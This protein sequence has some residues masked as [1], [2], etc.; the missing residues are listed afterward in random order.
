[1]ILLTG[2]TGKCGSAALKEL[3]KKGEA[4]RILARDEAKAAAL[5]GSGGA[6][7][8]AG[9]ATKQAD[10]DRALK[11]C[12]KVLMLLPN[13]QQQLELEKLFVDRAKAAGVRHVVKLSS[14]EATAETTLPIPAVHWASEEYLRASGLG[15]TMVKPNFF[16]QN[17]LG[18]AVTI[19]SMGKFFLPMSD[20]KTAMVD[21]RDVGAV[22]AKTLTSDGHAGKS[23]EIT[24]PELLTFGEVAERFSSVLGRKI[25]Y[26]DQPAAAYREFLAQF[27]TNPWHLNAVC[28]LF[29]AIAAGGIGYKTETVKTLLGR[30]PISLEQFIRDHAAAFQPQ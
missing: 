25:E 12:D 19:K 27:L 8:M 15:W 7:V 5:I 11:G 30:A 2:A 6:Q 18:N 16:M 10:L 4:L 26:V 13:S 20:G 1:M 21:C 23:Y 9:D 3:L 24:G 29:G 22:I 28:E 17:L 14:M